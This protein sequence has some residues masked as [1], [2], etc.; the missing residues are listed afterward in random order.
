MTSLL[1]I[2]LLH[3]SSNS[4][5]SSC[6]GHN[7]TMD[8]N[9]SADF[10][11]KMMNNT[12]FWFTV[13]IVPIGVVANILCLLVVSQKQNRSISCSVHMG[14][15]AVA[16]IIVLLTMGSQV[17]VENGFADRVS[18]WYCKASYYVLFT[19][20]LCGSMIIL[21]LLERVITVTKP[22]KAA[23]L[24]S[25]KRSLVITFVNCIALA[26]LNVPAFYAFA[27]D[28]TLV[29]RCGPT[30]LTTMVSR[31]V[32][33]F[34]MLFFRGILPLLGILIMNLVILCAIKSQKRRTTAVVSHYK[35]LDSQR[36]LADGQI[37]MSII[38]TSAGGITPQANPASSVE[39]TAIS[40]DPASIVPEIATSPDPACSAEE[41][42]ISPNPICSA[43]EI[44]IST[45]PV[46]I[47]PEIAISPNP[48]CSVEEIAIHP[49]PAS[50]V[51]ETAISTNPAS[52][53]EE[54][55]ISSNPA[56]SVEE[57]TISNIS[58]LTANKP[59]PNPVCSVDDVDIIITQER[60]IKNNQKQLTI[61][62]VVRTTATFCV[63][64]VTPFLLRSFYVYFAFQVQQNTVK[65]CINVV[66]LNLTALN[67]ATNFFIYFMTGSKFRSDLMTLF[68]MKC[69]RHYTT[70]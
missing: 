52:S 39:E 16:D 34:I 7:I 27:V 51:E 12:R 21:V 47:V 57:F 58:K 56:C 42:V 65:D 43:Q 55:A 49:N 10:Q 1:C 28:N 23:T 69:K 5:L 14:A 25:P 41:T 67:S 2:K 26:L 30:A 33:S 68:S 29:F 46:C 17:Y 6:F 9:T 64:C 40:T 11:Y 48:V 63:L 36:N 44:A 8:N 66:S 53:A 18:T 32:Y 54:I 45:N 50:S 22:L 62:T 19:S 3:P 35:V 70:E 61:M 60:K 13:I 37:E 38:S 20:S 15:L 4:P 31:T 24:L 59:E